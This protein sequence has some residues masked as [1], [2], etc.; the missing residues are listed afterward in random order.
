MDEKQFKDALRRREKRYAETGYQGSFM[1]GPL[2]QR[3]RKPIAVHMHISRYSISLRYAAI[4]FTT[5][6]HLAAT[7]D[8]HLFFMNVSLF[9]HLRFTVYLIALDI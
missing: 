9:T 7:L 2:E 1:D 4:L 8:C 6:S 5:L 3:I